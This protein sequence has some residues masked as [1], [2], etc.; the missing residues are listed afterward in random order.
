MDWLTLEYYNKMFNE[1]YG[2]QFIKNQKA[3]LRILD[4]IE[5]QRKVLSGNQEAAINVE[6]LYEDEDLNHVLTRKDYCSMMESF[7][8]RIKEELT[9]L[10][11][12]CDKQLIKVDEVE[13]IGGGT[14]I[15]AV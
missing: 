1:K 4:F 5:K 12:Q 13:I 10:K 15:P 6:C 11:Q 14:R 8:N 3:R 7:F 2:M 9:I